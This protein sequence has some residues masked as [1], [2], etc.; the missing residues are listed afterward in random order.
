MKKKKILVVDDDRMGG[1]MLQEF[2]E[3]EGYEAVAVE[4]GELALGEFKKSIFDL[5]LVDLM[6]PG[7]N[8]M[9]LLVELKALK[10]DL[11]VIILT[12]HNEIAS[13]IKAKELG[14]FEYVVKPVDF[15]VLQQMIF[16]I[17]ASLD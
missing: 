4:S 13:Y 3:R 14:A 16:S 1:I 17:F 8:G 9:E 2:L 7:M 11:P 10:P 12:A 6:M 5:A 15:I